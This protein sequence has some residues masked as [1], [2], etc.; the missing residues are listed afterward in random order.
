[1]K[2]ILVRH[3]QT[4]ANLEGL[5]QGWFESKLTALGR[6]EARALAKKLKNKKLD[7]IYA[8]DYSRAIDTA[9]AIL[10]FHKGLR[11]KTDKRIRERNLGIYEGIKMSDLGF[12]VLHPPLRPPKGETFAQMSKRVME[13]IREIAKKYEDETVLLATHAG[14]I[15]V[16]LAKATGMDFLSLKRRLLCPNCCVHR[17][18][19]DGR[20]KVKKMRVNEVRHVGS[21]LA[22]LVRGGGRG[23]IGT[24]TA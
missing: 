4:V 12:D 24:L 11:L 6:K 16:L 8:S 18:E 17:F 5:T 22:S 3:G 10:K 21:A 2:L 23:G 19:V 13:F 15:Y 14:P 1:M 9:K 7:V 20:G